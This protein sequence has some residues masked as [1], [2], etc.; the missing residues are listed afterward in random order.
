MHSYDVDEKIDAL[1]ERIRKGHPKAQIEFSRQVFNGHAELWVYVLSQ[2][3]YP[4]VEAQC[5]KLAKEC[6]AL[7]PPIWIF[8]KTWTGPW[9]GGE[10]ES[11]I[12]K[13]REEFRKRLQAQS[14]PQ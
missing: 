12:R 6:E 8:A 3:D 7:T 13:R 2:D 14:A 11:E 10:S 4:G 9:P 5:Q 1:K